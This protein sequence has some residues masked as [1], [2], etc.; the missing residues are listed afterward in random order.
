MLQIQSGSSVKKV[1]TKLDLVL[2]TKLVLL[3]CILVLKFSQVAY[4]G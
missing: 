4:K 3:K 1:S 2:V